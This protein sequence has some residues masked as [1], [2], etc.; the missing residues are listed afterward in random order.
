MA[1]SKAKKHCGRGRRPVHVKGSPKSPK[2]P[3]GRKS[4]N[5]CQT[6]W[7]HLL[8]LVHAKVGGKGLHDAMKK[9]TDMYQGPYKKAHTGADGKVKNITAAEMEAFVSAHM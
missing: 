7:S 9:A 1:S 6:A 8:K 5:R 2:H 3:K 4:Y